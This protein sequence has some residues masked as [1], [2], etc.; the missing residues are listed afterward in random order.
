MCIHVSEGC[1]GGGGREI[2]IAEVKE[3][4]GGGGGG[5]I[6]IAEVKEGYEH[7]AYSSVLG[8]A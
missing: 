4:Y 6:T 1:G 7:V 8:V 5:G 3:G 2:T